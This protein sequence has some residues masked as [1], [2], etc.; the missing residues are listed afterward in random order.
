[1]SGVEQVPLNTKATPHNVRYLRI[2]RDRLGHELH[3]G[4]G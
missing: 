1:M 3:L 4:N 2:T